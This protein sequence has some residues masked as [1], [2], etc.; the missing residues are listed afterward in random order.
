MDNPDHEEDFFDPLKRI[1]IGNDVLLSFGGQFWYRYM[2]ET[3]SRLNAAGR[4]NNFHLTRLRAHVDIWYQDKIRFFGEFIDAR[5]WGQEL[6]PLGIDRN[7][8][9]HVKYLYGCKIS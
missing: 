6:Q 1:Q 4:N 5:T 7:S 8:H 3:D 9:G 2:R